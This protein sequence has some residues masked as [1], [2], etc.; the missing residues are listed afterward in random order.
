MAPRRVQLRV[1][2]AFA[3]L[4]ILLAAIGIHGLLSFTVTDR[5]REIGVRIALGA[6]RRSVLT[7]VLREGLVLGAAGVVLGALLGYGAGQAMQALLA[8]IHP[9]DALT[10]GATIAVSTTVVVLGSLLPA[11]R[12]AAVDPN[13]AMRDS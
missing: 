10:F 6:K 5:A 12:A 4:A 7:M 9:A 1:L 13:V 8:G 11:L 2:G 3:A